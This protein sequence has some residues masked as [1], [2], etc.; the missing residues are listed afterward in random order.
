VTALDSTPR[1]GNGLTFV[2]LGYIHAAMMYDYLVTTKLKNDKIN[3]VV[4]QLNLVGSI[5]SH[6]VTTRY[7]HFEI[8][9][10]TVSFL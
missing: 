10:V 4:T 1:D 3:L 2:F 8:H 6:T 9:V 7:Y 5:D